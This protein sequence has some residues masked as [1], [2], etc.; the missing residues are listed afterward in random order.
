MKPTLNT[1]TNA[2]EIQNDKEVDEIELHQEQMVHRD[3]TGLTRKISGIKN[4][5]A[6]TKPGAYNLQYPEIPRTAYKT[7]MTGT[8]FEKSVCKLLP[9]G[10]VTEQ[11]TEFKEKVLCMV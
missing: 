3:Y 1:C 6:T 2:L 4:R 10:Y 11:D 7:E 9:S 5:H 8:I